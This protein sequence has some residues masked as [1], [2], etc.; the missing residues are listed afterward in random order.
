MGTSACS[1]Q[2]DWA[3][4]SER[5]AGDRGD[6]LAGTHWSMEIWDSQTWQKVG[7]IGGT[8]PV[9]HGGSFYYAAS[10]LAW[11]PNGTTIA[12]GMD[13]DVWLIHLAYDQGS[14]RQIRTSILSAA[15][16][17]SSAGFASN[18]LTWAPNSRYLAVSQN[19]VY[20][21]LNVYDVS[22][23]KN[24]L[25]GANSSGGAFVALSW[26]TNSKSIKTTDESNIISTWKII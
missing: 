4:W 21:G 19:E 22:N 7:K 8:L 16:A 24:V 23:E 25:S 14:P 15:A 12:V 2:R 11:S 9:S 13:N 1:H 5:A 17:N 6:W 18:M 20:G 3:D 10:G 26:A